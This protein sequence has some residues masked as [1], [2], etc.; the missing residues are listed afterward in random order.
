MGYDRSI[1]S[2]PGWLRTERAKDKIKMPLTIRKVNKS[3]L[4]ARAATPGRTRKPSDF[5]DLVI[6]AYEAWQADPEEA[7]Y[8][9]EFDGSKEEYEDLVGELN[10]AVL[11]FRD[12]DGETIYGKSIR[13]GYNE[14]TDEVTRNENGKPV[15]WFQVRDK[16]KTGGRGPRKN[17]KENDDNSNGK[18][19]HALAS[20]D[21]AESPKRGRKTGLAEPLFT[22]HGA[23]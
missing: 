21:D 9:V 8:E 6:P 14:E 7:W 5:D 4:P 18:A 16:L 22:D 12:D 19:E 3:V 20:V 11:N 1:N 13:G 10:R 17:R 2:Q 15:F 23:G